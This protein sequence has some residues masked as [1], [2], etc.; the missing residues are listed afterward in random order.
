MSWN[1]RL[2]TPHDG[3]N[4]WQN[5][6]PDFCAHLRDE[7]ADIMGFQ[8]VLHNQLL[9]LQSCL[10]GYT[11][12]GVGRSDGKTG[13]EHSPI[14]FREDRFGLI[15]SG[16]NWLSET[17]DVPG[18]VGWDAALER[19]V[20]WAMLND[21]ASGDTILVMNTH[22][23][24]VGQ[25]A[26]EQS[27]DFI[28]KLSAGLAKGKPVVMMGDLNAT[29]DNHAYGR[30]VDAGMIDARNAASSYW[31]DKPTYTGFDENP[32]NDALIDYILHSPHFRVIEY[33]VQQV[34]RNG[35]YLSDHLP[36][37]ARMVLVKR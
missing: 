24:H 35:Q 34:N 14:F 20:S 36:V 5:R 23:D 18:S 7:R 27:A 4:A 15:K 9:D 10:E 1:I 32:D 21:F 29:P 8:E 31:A 16:T 25:R 12:I 3:A 30:F 17:P 22:F 6:R 2:D 28:V 13:G 26:R 11:Y 19:I 37:M 33:Q